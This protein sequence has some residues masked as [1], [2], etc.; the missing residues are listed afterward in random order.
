[1][2]DKIKNFGLSGVASDVQLGKAGNRLKSSEGAIEARNAAGNELAKIRA[3]AAVDPNDVVILSQLQNLSGELDGFH[4]QLGDVT[5]DGDGSWQPGAVPL[6]NDTPVS[7]AIDKMN[8]ILALLTPDAP[9]NFPNGT[10]S[11]SNSSGTSPLLADGAVPD[12]TGGS[13]LSAG[14]SVTRITATG[15]NSNTFQDVGPGDSGTVSLIVNGSAVGSRTLTGSG[16]AGTYNGLVIA[17]Q[18]DYPTDT[19]GFWKSIDVSVSNAAVQQGINSFKLTHSGAGSTNEVVFV[20]DN[21]TAT[22]AVSNGSVTQEAAGTFAYS[23]SVPHYGNG[24]QIKVALSM[25]NLAGETYY[26]G[27]NPLTIT[28]TNGIFSS[29]TYTYAN[30]GIVTPIARQTTSA[31]AITPVTIS[32]NGNNVHASGVVQATARNVNGASSATTVSPV[33]ILVKR[34]TAPTTKIDEMSI[35][36]TGLGSAPNTNNAVRVGGFDDDDT[37]SGTASEWDATE[38]LP[39]HEATVVA[40]V[41]KHDTTDYSTGYLPVG[42]DLSVG[43]D[44]AQYATFSFNRAAVST[45]KIKVTGS[46]A[47]VWVKLPGVSDNATISPNGAA[48]N[49]WWDAF[50]P[51]DGAGVPGET[52]DSTNGCALG[53]VMTGSSGT[54]TITFGTQSST[55]ATGN[56]I[57]VRIKLTAGQSITELSFSN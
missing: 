38:E 34:G 52:G 39:A 30:I 24:G 9:P 46:Y 7:Q 8:A 50:K 15:V 17:D 23:S 49:G 22:P 12:N 28:G 4:I 40:G 13:T 21:L 45:F 56:T 36:V 35:P 11:V 25:S 10:L 47:G 57:L 42:P 54:F 41:L 16:D 51:Y 5:T 2:A 20:R 32:V 26:G 55:N 6:T 14:D 31:V 3:A 53:T 27:N 43:R 18:K 48:A 1:M 19:P 37:A 33:T 29:Q 44:G